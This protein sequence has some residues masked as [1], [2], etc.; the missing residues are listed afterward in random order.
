MTTECWHLVNDTK[1]YIQVTDTRSC[2]DIAHDVPMQTWSHF[3]GEHF[4]PPPVHSVYLDTQTQLISQFGNWLDVN[5][6]T[7]LAGNVYWWFTIRSFSTVLKLP[8]S[9]TAEFVL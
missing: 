1:F 3:R 2:F 4:S 9:D 7:L 5:L 8:V 6:I